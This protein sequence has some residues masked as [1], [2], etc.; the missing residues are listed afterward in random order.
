MTVAPAEQRKAYWVD[1]FTRDR[2]QGNPAV[3]IPEAENLTDTQMQQIAREVNCSETAFVSP[4]SETGADLQLRWF[5]P[6]MEVGLCGHATVATLHVLYSRGWTASST[7]ASPSSSLQT[8]KLQTLSGILPVTIDTSAPEATWFWLTVPPCDFQAVPPEQVISLQAALGL[9]VSAPEMLVSESST[10]SDSASE[11]VR[12]LLAVVDSLNQDVLL[13][14]STLKELHQLQPNMTELA[15]LGRQQ[16]WRGICV[17]TLETVDTTNLAHLRFFAP[18]CGIAEDPVTGSVSVPLVSYLQHRQGLSEQMEQVTL[19]QGDCLG[20]AG[21]VR[22]DLQ[23]ELP[24]L[25]GQAV[26]VMEGELYL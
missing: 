16:G 24:R 26:T 8:L 11:D 6:T 13:H 5:T 25:G 18:H 19:E 1:A 9:E 3:V 22:V 12:D 4:A 20:R 14:I 7:G 17:Y 23:G 21:R 15:A 10:N 2:F